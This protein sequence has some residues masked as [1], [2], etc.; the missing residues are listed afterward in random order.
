EAYIQFQD[1]EPEDS[2]LRLVDEVERLLV[3]RTFSKI[4]GISGLRAGYAVGSGS[5]AR[6]LDAIAPALGVNALT[7]AAVEHALRFGTDEIARRRELV[8]EQRRRLE[9]ALHDLAVDAPPSQANFLW[10]SAA[11]LTGSELTAR[12]EQK[13][14]IVAPGGPLGADDHARAAVRGAAAT[15]RLLEALQ[16]IAAP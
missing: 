6:L 3:F 9:G 7:Q 15:D 1:V 11:G 13:G 8:I 16:L 2:V 10:L 14:V 4:Y 12:L 5:A